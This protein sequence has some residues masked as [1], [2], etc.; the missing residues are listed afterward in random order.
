MH[1]LNRTPLRRRKAWFPRGRIRELKNERRENGRYL[2]AN[3]NRGLRILRNIIFT[4]ACRNDYWPG[5][6]HCRWRY[7]NA[8]GCAEPGTPNQFGGNRRTGISTSFRP[9]SKDQPRRLGARPASHGKLQQ[10]RPI[11]ARD[12]RRKRRRQ[13]YWTRAN[14]YRHGV[15]V[16]AK[17][18][19]ANRA[20]T[21]QLSASRV[22]RKNSSARFL[23]QQQPNPAVGLAA[24]A[25]R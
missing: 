11:A 3:R 6:K 2:Q 25:I 15:V 16:L 18:G 20:N 9:A 8:T 24:W 21:N 19:R 5:D 10:G 12:L 17:R 23:E 4:S 7:P 1:P 13:R 22:Q 14:S